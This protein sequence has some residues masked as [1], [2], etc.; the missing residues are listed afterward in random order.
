M[1]SGEVAMID[2]GKR[3]HLAAAGAQERETRIGCVV[4]PSTVDPQLGS[5][6]TDRS[7]YTRIAEK[8]AGV[9]DALELAHLEEVIHRDI[10]PANLLLDAD[11][12]LKVVDFG[13]ARLENDGPS[14]TITGALLVIEPLDEPVGN[15]QVELL[16]YAVEERRRRP[17][18][19]H[20]PHTLPNGRMAQPEG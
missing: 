2:A 19:I 17:P 7:Y 5:D 6:S 20:G 4:G 8:F 14:M 18:A 13:L 3:S 11:G 9:A 15:V 16:G 10:K 1:P 12:T